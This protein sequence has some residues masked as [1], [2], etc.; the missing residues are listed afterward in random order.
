MSYRTLNEYKESMFSNV[1]DALAKHEDRVGNI[2]L[3]FAKSVRD[4][5]LLP[6]CKRHNIEFIS[7][8][9]S[10]FFRTRSGRILYAE[11]MIGDWKISSR[12]ADT[13]AVPEFLTEFYQ[14]V[15]LLCDPIGGLPVGDWMDDVDFE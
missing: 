5:V 12:L 3:A 15:Q 7:G 2:H 4:Q 1:H 13:H 6:F 11:D 9:G 10:F 8:N 14:L